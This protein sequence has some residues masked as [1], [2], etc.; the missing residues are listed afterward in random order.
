MRSPIWAPW[1]ME[2]LLAKKDH[3]RCIFCD[4]P[5]EPSTKHRERLVLLANEQGAVMLNRY[6]FASGHLL[7]VPRAH[8]ARL[9]DLDD[10]A[11]DGLFRLVRETQ[12]RLKAAVG[13]P[14]LNIGLNLGEAAGAGIA[15]HLHVHIVPRW[16]GDTNFM[17]VIADV[18][19]MPQ[20]LDETYERLR[21][22]FADL[23]GVSPA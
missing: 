20:Y 19:V 18:R 6:P 5:A 22:H 17:P 4:Y 12:K 3:T 8:V 2:Y 15:E 23:P 21:P 16:P 9:E 1:R 10:A 14:A 13:A 7:V 11:Y